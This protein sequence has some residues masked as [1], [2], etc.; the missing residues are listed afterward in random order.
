MFFATALA[1]LGLQLLVYSPA[2]AIRC[3]CTDEHC[4]PNGICEANVCLVGLLKVNSAVIRSCGNEP[5]GCQRNVDKWSDLCACDHSFC[6]SFAYLRANTYKERI[7]SNRDGGGE[8][9][10]FQRVDPPLG[11][12]PGMSPLCH[13]MTNQ[14]HSILTADSFARNCAIISGGSYSAGGCFQLLLPFVLT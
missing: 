3:Y 10:V 14:P 7:R 11:D 6:N 5:L 12:F 1:F 13:M 2:R 4:V 9:L 8:D